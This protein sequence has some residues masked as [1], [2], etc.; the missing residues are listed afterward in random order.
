MV[1]PVK[2]V[3]RLDA[4]ESW[5]RLKSGRRAFLGGFLSASLLLRK[6]EAASGQAGAA[7]PALDAGSLAT[8]EA[9]A[10]T[11][12]PRDR[13]PGAVDAGVPRR[14]LAHL[15]AHPEALAL[16]RAG[17]ELLDRLAQQAGASSFRAL[18]ALERERVIASLGPGPEAAQRVGEQFFVRVRRDVL[19]FYWG[20]AVGQSVVGYRPPLSG[21]PDYADPPRRFRGSRP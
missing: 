3:P 5:C 13:D 15:S 4:L 16:Y 9:V 1:E 21:Y 20:S 10:D 8:L 7:A 6:P 18:D 19:A 11:I 17:L 2:D 14:I 12:V